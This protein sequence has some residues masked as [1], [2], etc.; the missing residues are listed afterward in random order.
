MK[1]LKPLFAAALL[2]LAATPALAH[3]NANAPYNTAIQIQRT[4]P[5][6]ELHD[7]APHARWKFAVVDPVTK[8]QSVWTLEGVNSSELHR[9]GLLVRT[10]LKPGSTMTFI[11]SPSRDGSDTGLLKAIIIEGKTYRLATY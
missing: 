11:F 2:G 4:G 3:H 8:A 7:V 6:I 9:M 5:L 10:D 1:P